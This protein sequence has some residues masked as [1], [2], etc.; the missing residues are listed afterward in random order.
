[1][2]GHECF[3]D[4]IWVSH[5]IFIGSGKYGVAQWATFICE[6]LYE[7]MGKTRLKSLII[8]RHFKTDS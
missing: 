2:G 6:F 5:S 8:K 4:N 3:P 1:M 7:S